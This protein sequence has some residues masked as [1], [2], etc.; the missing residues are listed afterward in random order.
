MGELKENI[1]VIGS[2]DLDIMESNSLPSIS[3]VKKHYE[4]KIIIMQ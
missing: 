1:F 2:P 3:E 4:I